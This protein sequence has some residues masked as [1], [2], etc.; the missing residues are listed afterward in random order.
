MHAAIDQRVAD[1]ADTDGDGDVDDDDLSLLLS[2][3]TGTPAPLGTAVPEPAALLA[4]AVLA[5]FGA[6]TLFR[7]LNPTETLRLEKLA[8]Y[9]R[10][11]PPTSR[12]AIRRSRGQL[13]R[14]AMFPDTIRSRRL[15]SSMMVYVYFSSRVRFSFPV[16]A[17]RSARATSRTG[18]TGSSASSSTPTSHL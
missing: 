8:R 10:W 13:P 14:L 15:A 12:R 18:P 16:C 17:T 4:L 5:A 11:A 6:E 2:N 9:S 3:W 7:A 1:L